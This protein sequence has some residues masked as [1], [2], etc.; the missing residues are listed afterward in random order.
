M[1]RGQGRGVGGLDN[2]RLSL[3]QGIVGE[4]YLESGNAEGLSWELQSE[5]GQNPFPQAFPV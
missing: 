3:K 2:Q 5:R 1:G 4:Q